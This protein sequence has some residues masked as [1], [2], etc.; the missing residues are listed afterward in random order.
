MGMGVIKQSKQVCLTDSHRMHTPAS[1]VG[2]HTETSK[3]S[4]LFVVIIRQQGDKAVI[5]MTHQLVLNPVVLIQQS[6]N[7][8]YAVMKTLLVIGIQRVCI[9]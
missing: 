3:N 2:K 1:D 4:M 5:Y 7:N 8:E 9:S 6:H